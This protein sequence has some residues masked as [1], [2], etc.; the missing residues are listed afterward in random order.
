MDDA[1]SIFATGSGTFAD[2]WADPACMHFGADACRRAAI[3]DHCAGLRN[4]AKTLK[5]DK[6]FLQ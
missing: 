6:I 3:E 4:L 2:I 1:A 5:I